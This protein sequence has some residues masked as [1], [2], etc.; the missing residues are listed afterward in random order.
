ML[1]LAK[2]E[3]SKK[4]RKTHSC[5]LG[6]HTPILV[7]FTRVGPP[8]CH[9]GKFGIF[10]GPNSKKGVK[11]QCLFRKNPKK[12]H[13]FQNSKKWRFFDQNFDQNFIIFF[14]DKKLM[15]FGPPKMGVKFNVSSVNSWFWG[16][17]GGPGTLKILENWGSKWMFSSVNNTFYNMS[18]VSPGSSGGPWGGSR[19]RKGLWGGVKN[20]VFKRR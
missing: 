20:D 3:S 13:F 2:S 11:S 19:G 12:C 17:W 5:T 4:T 15:I 18:R 9:S 16:F 7:I 8:K 10:R 1:F 14:N 6:K